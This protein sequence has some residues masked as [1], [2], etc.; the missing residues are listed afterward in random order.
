MDEGRGFSMNA[1]ASS[2][3]LY[4]NERTAKIAF[5]G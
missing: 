3:L 2:H 1:S 4:G 5:V